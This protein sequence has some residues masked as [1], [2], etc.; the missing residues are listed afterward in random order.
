MQTVVT[1]KTPPGPHSGIPLKN[2]LGFQR[3]SLRFFTETARYGDVSTFKVGSIPLYLVSHPDLIRD[4]LV[5]RAKD[6]HKSLAFE[7]LKPLLGNGLLTSEDE[8]HHRQRRLAAPAFHRQRLVAYGEDMT[9]YAVQTGERWQPG[10]VVDM[11]AEMMRLTL[12]IAGKTLFG[13]D[14]EQEAPEVGQ[15]LTD[16]MHAFI[17]LNSPLAPLLDRLSFLPSNRKAEAAIRQLDAIVYRMIAERRKSGVDRGDLLSMLLE[18][19]DEEGDQTGMTDRQVR[20]ESMTIFL[21]G[22]ETT[23]VL[24]TWTWYLLSQHPRVAEKLHA[25]VDGVL[26]GRAPGVDDLPKLT[27]TRQV[28]SETLRLYPPAYATGRRALVDYQ[29]G[30]YLIPAGSN[31]ILSQWVVQHDPRWWPDPLAFQP[32]RW[33]PEAEASRPR[34]AY[35]PF[36]GGPRVC[37]GEQFAWMEG[38]LILAALSQRWQPRLEPGFTVGMEPLITLRPKNGMRML[39]EKRA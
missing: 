29:A 13:A 26:A 23:A 10:Q 9:A 37:I 14:V 20:D 4:I 24:L 6:F 36:G 18:A 3:D 39:L 35:F 25:E 5:T 34:F 7:R 21:A 8:F 19:R 11:A 27:Y 17:R 16:V 1:P 12:A 30:E 22:H 38:T 28:L 2:L 33:T 31:I 32:E 15:A